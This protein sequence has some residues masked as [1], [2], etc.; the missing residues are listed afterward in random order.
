ME[1]HCHI[2]ELLLYATGWILFLSCFVHSRGGPIASSI[3][4]IGLL[5]L[6]G[7]LIFGGIG[8]AMGGRRMFLPCSLCATSVWLLLHVVLA[9]IHRL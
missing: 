3:A 6:P 7:T 2:S 4:L 5:L 1:R 8:F 9:S